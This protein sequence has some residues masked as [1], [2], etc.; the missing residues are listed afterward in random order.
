MTSLAIPSVPPP[1]VA[2]ADAASPTADNG[3][4][5][6]NALRESQA[7]PKATSDGHSSDPDAGSSPRKGAGADVAKQDDKAD[8]KDVTMVPG[9]I[10]T[11]PVAPVPVRQSAATAGK[12]VPAAAPPAGVQS[13]GR[14]PQPLS[15]ALLTTQAQVVNTAGDNAP[16][17]GK[18]P[19]L[20]ASGDK[21]SALGLQLANA[22][23]TDS[24]DEH[25]PIAPPAG[26]EAAESATPATDIATALGAS[27][28]DANPPTADSAG[29]TRTAQ[30]SGPGLFA[31]Q[32]AQLAGMHAGTTSAQPSAA[33]AQLTMQSSPGQPQFAQEA[34]Q[35]VSWLAGQ[36]IQ[37]AEIQLNPKKLG[38]I[39]VE[40]TTHHDRVDVSFAVQHPQT[41]HALQ[42]TLPQLHDM[43]AQQGL[44]LGHASVGHQTPGRQHAAFAQHAGAGGADRDSG[45][46]QADAPPAWRTL[47]VAVPGRVDDFA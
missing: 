23:M 11:L 37:Q 1:P 29:D 17:V 47:R 19:A 34:A 36:N 13:A 8:A 25:A 46:G 32:L 30:N 14:Q 40:I 18:T 35:H 41:V 21:A 45:S 20:R 22:T 33:P 28:L 39:Q 16:V 42:Q 4:H 3:S 12:P 43:L 27:A 31:A 6:G 7:Q 2:N 44:N 5:F 26:S 9:M 10:P 15:P 24:S 38:P